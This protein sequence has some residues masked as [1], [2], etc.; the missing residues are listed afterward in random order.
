MTVC[1]TVVSKKG[2]LMVSSGENV[3]FESSKALTSE[4][5][6]PMTD[7]SHLILCL[8]PSI[9]SRMCLEP[10]SSQY[11]ESFIPGTY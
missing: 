1:E 11:P 4:V 2:C 8:P 5:K 9:S 3:E 10:P 7:S 6:A